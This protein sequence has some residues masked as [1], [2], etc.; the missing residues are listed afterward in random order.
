MTRPR[1]IRIPAVAALLSA[2]LSLA[3]AL[4]AAAGEKPYVQDK[5]PRGWHFFL[6]PKRDNAADQWEHVQSL[7]Q[8]GK[9]KK[10]A[11]QAKALRIWWPLSPEAPAAQMFYAR[12]MDRRGKLEDAF[13]AYQL[14]LSDYGAQCDFDAVLADQLRLANAILVQRRCAFWGL[15]GFE[16]PE[17]AI[18]YY[19]QIA[20]IAPEWSG[21][22]EALFRK[23]QANEREHNWEA[24]VEAYFQ[25]MNRFPESEFAADAA[26]AQA[27]CQV[28]VADE[29]PN[30]A[31][32]RE[33]AIAACDL[34]RTRY[35][36]AP[37]VGDAIRDRDRLVERRRDA[38]WKLALYYDK[39]LKNPEAA[40]IHYREFAALYPDAPE[41]PVALA[42]LAALGGD[43]TPPSEPK[44]S[45]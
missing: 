13:D 3:G 23:G 18:P 7:A 5:L 12:E 15:P 31:R 26:V 27:R 6:H 17:R 25:T 41:C 22:A 11:R 1:A 19:D 43:D 38:A 40:R 21:A 4:P 10:A 16:S 33:I 2:A 30:D 24:A 42:R 34:V 32:A 29:T 28:A 20:E 35:P 45:P 44:D 9:L 39:T 14:L 36:N 37:R 8:A